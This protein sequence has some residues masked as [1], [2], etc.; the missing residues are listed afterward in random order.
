VLTAT[1]AFIVVIA[2]MPVGY[3]AIAVLEDRFPTVHQPPARI[4]GIIVL[5][6][7]VNQFMTM[8]RG[9]PA[10]T[11]G[12][13]RLT[14]FV[15]LAR[16]HPEA[17]LVFTGGS[18][19]VFMQ[20][21]KESEVARMFF[22][23]MGLD[24]SRIV[25]ESESRN[26]WENAVF[27]HRLMQPR[28]GAVWVLITSALHMPR[29]VG[30]FRKAGWTP[31]PFPVDYLTYGHLHLTPRLDLGGGIDDLWTAMREWM[32]LAAYRILGR[33]DTVLPAPKR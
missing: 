4:D 25:F 30:A 14:E 12:A 26:T 6:G 33:T 15:A 22:D 23:Q 9:Q 17:R 19:A 13:E 10:L 27:T 29:A 16:R 32:A 24:T 21:L 7:T 2:T 5:G 31:L 8:A 28:P 20:E 1:V 11:D 3:M 18:A